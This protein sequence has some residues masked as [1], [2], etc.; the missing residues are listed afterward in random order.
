M[1]RN[2]NMNIDTDRLPDVTRG[3]MQRTVGYLATWGL[4]RFSEVSISN[5]GTNNL[6]AGYSNQEGE[7]GFVIGAVWRENDQE[8]TFHS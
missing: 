4:S 1:E 6:I 8:Y 7:V 3:E 2:V 5:D